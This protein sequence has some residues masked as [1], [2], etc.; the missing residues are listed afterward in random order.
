VPHLAQTP[1]VAGLPFF[2]LM[3]LAFFISLLAL[4]FMQ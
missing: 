1:W 2:I 4:H 3:A